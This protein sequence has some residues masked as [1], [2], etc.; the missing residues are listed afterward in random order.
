[1]H[2]HMHMHTHARMPKHTRTHTHTSIFGQSALL[3]IRVVGISLSAYSSSSS[4]TYAYNVITRSLWKSTCQANYHSPWL[5]QFILL[6]R[7]GVEKY[8]KDLLSYLM[9]CI[10]LIKRYG[11]LETS[12]IIT[13]YQPYPF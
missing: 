13:V 9:K 2:A 7:L 5:K 10:E 3:L 12:V 11:K 6:R 4:N 8:P 1:M